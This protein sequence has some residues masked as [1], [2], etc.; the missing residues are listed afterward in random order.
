MVKGLKLVNRSRFSFLRERASERFWE[1]ALRRSSND[2]HDFE[3]YVLPGDRIGN[4]TIA[5]GLFER[6]EIQ[7]LEHLLK[8]RRSGSEH[9]KPG[10]FLDV[11]AN[12]GA[13]SVAFSS[14]FG[15]VIAFEPNPVVAHVLRANLAQ[16]RCLNVNVVEK[17]LGATATQASLFSIERWNVGMASLTPNKEA[18][19]IAKVDVVRG[20]DFLK[21]LVQEGSR[22][23]LLK[24]DV[25]GHEPRALEGLLE[26]LKAHQPLIAFEVRGT[27]LANEITDIL[28]SA[29]YKYFYWIERPKWQPVMGRLGRVLELTWLGADI[30]LTPIQTFSETFYSMIVGSPTSF[31]S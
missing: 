15:Q 20:D 30:W 25:E 17:A 8:L 4:V 14:L 19:E 12:I 26:T 28:S 2:R 9:S 29:G 21:P 6:R 31:D 16:N 7:A 27:K 11:G 22:I 3:F 18:V 13:Y 1:T 10:I 23:E 24:I 5:N